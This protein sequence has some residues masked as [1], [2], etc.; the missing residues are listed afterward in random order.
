M[1]VQTVLP[2]LPS[3]GPVC[4]SLVLSEGKVASLW[5]GWVGR[6]FLCIPAAELSYG[7]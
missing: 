2:L 1:W 6:G 3:Q 4:S 5:L 7:S